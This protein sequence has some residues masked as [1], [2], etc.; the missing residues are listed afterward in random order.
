ML[1]L[2]SAILFYFS[3]FLSSDY[4]SYVSLFLPFCGILGNSV[5]FISDFFIVVLS[6]SLCVDSIVVAA[7][8]TIYGCD[9]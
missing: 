9:S 2:K 4:D 7:G 3:K 8:I 1:A 6:I 5:G